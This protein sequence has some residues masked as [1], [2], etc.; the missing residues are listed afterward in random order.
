MALFGLSVGY[1]LPEMRLG[2]LLMLLK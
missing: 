1:E 2:K